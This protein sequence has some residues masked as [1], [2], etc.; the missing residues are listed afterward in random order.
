M[1]NIESTDK[2][3]K[4]TEILE[5][6]MATWTQKGNEQNKKINWKFTKEKTEKKISKY[7]I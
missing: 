6:K 5:Y 2:Q 4:N 7:Y 1:M 3:I